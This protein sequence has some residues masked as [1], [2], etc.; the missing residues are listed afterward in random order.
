[1][2]NFT[3]KHFLDKMERHRARIDE[4]AGKLHGVARERGRIIMTHKG[5]SHQIKDDETDEAKFEVSRA[6]NNL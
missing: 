3:A 6:I 1:M 5:R 4:M 2:F